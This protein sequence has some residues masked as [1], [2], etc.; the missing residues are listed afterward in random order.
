MTVTLLPNTELVAKAWLQT[1]PGVPVGQINT[2]LPTDTSKWAATGFIQIT[3]VG[4][5][6]GLYSPMRMPVVQLDFWAVSPS[7]EKAPWGKAN[8]LAE[9][10]VAGCYIRELQEKIVDLG[11]FGKAFVREAFPLTEP[12]RIPDEQSDYARY[13]ADFHFFWTAV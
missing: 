12:R 13:Q 10:V 8:N 2:T 11:S 6:P 5:N 4:G 1:L 9:T 3:S 7:S